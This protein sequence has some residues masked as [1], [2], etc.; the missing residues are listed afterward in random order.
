MATWILTPSVMAYSAIA[1]TNGTNGV[2]TNVPCAGTSHF[3]HPLITVIMQYRPTMSSIAVNKCC[4]HPMIPRRFED[5]QTYRTVNT[6]ESSL[7]GIWTVIKKKK[8][9]WFDP[10]N[11]H[12]ATQLGDDTGNSWCKCT[13]PNSLHD[14]WNL[15]ER[16]KTIRANLD[17]DMQSTKVG[18]M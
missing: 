2:T 15:K 1:T 7:R 6:D 18:S 12:W 3:Y 8:K 9:T 13:C 16:N 5:W 14:K 11:R 4:A 10:I 17:F